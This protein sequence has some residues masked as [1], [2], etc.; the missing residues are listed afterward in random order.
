ML[1]RSILSIGI[2]M[3]KLP[4]ELKYKCINCKVET[5]ES[6]LLLKDYIKA[7]KE[8]IS[9]IRCCSMCHYGFFGKIFAELVIHNI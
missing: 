8:V 4:F 1:L 7:R 5:E 9:G 3:N 6:F 2:N